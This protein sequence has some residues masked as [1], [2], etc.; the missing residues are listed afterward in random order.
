MR[1]LLTPRY[2]ARLAAGAQDVARAQGLRAL[3]FR[4]AGQSDA[5]RFDSRADHLLVETH[6]GEV[7]ATFRI[8]TFNAGDDLGQSYA[9]QFYDLTAFASQSGCKA[10]VGRFCLHP[11]SHDPDLVRLCW[12]ALARLALGQ[13]VDHVFG[14]TSLPGADAQTH[15]PALAWLAQTALGPVE[16][17]PRPRAQALAMA[18]KAADAKG[19]PDLLR[20]YLAMGGWVADHALIDRDL[21]TVHVFTALDLT[22]LTPARAKRLRALATLGQ[23]AAAPVDAARKAV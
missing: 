1:E 9:A 21:D 4:R 18:G 22:E 16:V 17:R 20:F 10:E 2:R 8:A 15:A 13:R 6:A 23:T 12:A 3:A 11:L 5:D 14:C 19:V 7:L